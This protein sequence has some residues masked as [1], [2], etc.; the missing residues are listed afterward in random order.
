MI[1]AL[2]LAGVR[3]RTAR[4]YASAAVRHERDNPTFIE[5][6]GRGNI[7]TAANGPHKSLNVEG[8]GAL[9]LATTESNGEHWDFPRRS[10]RDEARRMVVD[11]KPTWLTA[12]PPC[13]AFSL[14][15]Y[16]NY[17][18]LQPEKAD[19]KKTAG[20]VNLKMLLTCTRCK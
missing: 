10:H 13:T 1:N 8:L 17:A 20:L 19:R 9:Y 7:V 11:L 18:L 16:V 12:S 6:F 3:K 15:H 4:E 14:W 5:V 2:T